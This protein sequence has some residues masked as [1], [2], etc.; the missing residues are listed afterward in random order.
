MF[1][2]GGG[3]EERPVSVRLTP[4][5]NKTPQVV[6]L[7]GGEVPESRRNRKQTRRAAG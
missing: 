3:L 2:K 5:T 6:T 1:L 7:T 4:S